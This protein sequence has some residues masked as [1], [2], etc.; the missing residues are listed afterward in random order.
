MPLIPLLSKVT[1]GGYRRRNGEDGLPQRHAALRQHG[2]HH[3]GSER[4]GTSRHDRDGGG[5]RQ[6]G[7]LLVCINQDS[8]LHEFLRK[9]ERFCVNVLQVG[10]LPVSRAFSSA[11]SSVER[12]AH[13][14]WQ[15][16]HGIPY[17]AD[18]Q[19]N[20]FCV[21][22]VEV[23]YGSHTI[24]IGRVFDARVRNDIRPLLYR[25]G[26]YTECMGSETLLAPL[27]S[28]QVKAPT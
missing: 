25:N 23:P 10:N 3:L 20:L 14:D 8:R 15:A 2:Q 6:P 7:S 9:E 4:I 27:A 24:F 17:L 13:G 16:D 5:F 19:A 18:A 21:R 11:I 12:F 22:E 26:G 1:V 28:A